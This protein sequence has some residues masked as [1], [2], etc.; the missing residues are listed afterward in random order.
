MKDGNDIGAT[1]FLVACAFLIGLLL[2][3]GCTFDAMQ[4]R[5]VESGHA[6]FFVDKEHRKEFRWKACLGCQWEAK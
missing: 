4:E 6:E 3:G 5:A 2:S 1:L